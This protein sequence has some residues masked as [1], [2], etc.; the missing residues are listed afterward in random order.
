MLSN[1]SSVIA[2]N[3][4]L[5]VLKDDVVFQECPEQK[6]G[7]IRTL[8]FSWKTYSGRCKEWGFVFDMGSRYKLPAKFATQYGVT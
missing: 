7:L 2:Y 5:H 1:N 6:A 3:L 4:W 8:E